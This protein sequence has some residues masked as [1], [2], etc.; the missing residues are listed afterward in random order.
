MPSWKNVSRAFTRPIQPT[1]VSENQG[2]QGIRHRNQYCG[3]K[4]CAKI[5]D[6]GVP[7]FFVSEPEKECINNDEKNAQSQKNKRQA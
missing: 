2:E 6:L 3:N 5:F 4:R 1:R 7:E